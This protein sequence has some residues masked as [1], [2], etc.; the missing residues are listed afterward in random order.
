MSFCVEI[1]LI[2]TLFSILFHLK[3]QQNSNP[4]EMIFTLIMIFTSFVP[5]FCFC[6]FGERI[7]QKLSMFDEKLWQCD[8]HA[9]SIEMQKLMLTFMS[10]TQ[11]LTTFRG[12]ANTE[13]TRDAFKTVNSVLIK[14][15]SQS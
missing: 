10:S 7:G 2:L 14:K 5:N 6:E 11:R 9:F 4:I 13:C 1:L 8:W 3:S 12:Y 15:M